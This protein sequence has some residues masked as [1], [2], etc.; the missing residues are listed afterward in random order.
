MIGQ[1]KVVTDCPSGMCLQ[2]V[3]LM[4]LT[5]YSHFTAVCFTAVISKNTQPSATR[6]DGSR[7]EGVDTEERGVEGAT[8]RSLVLEQRERETE[9][10]RNDNKGW[11]TNIKRGSP[12]R[13]SHRQ[14]LIT[15]WVG[16][17]TPAGPLPDWGRGEGVTSPKADWS[18]GIAVTHIASF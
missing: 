4:Q 9:I 15:V 3:L 12:D 5:K 2:R 18:A 17:Q 1:N 8:E 16:G 10:Q 11:S 7:G 13:N 6:G 14:V